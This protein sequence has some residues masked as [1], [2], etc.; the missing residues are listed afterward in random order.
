MNPLCLPLLNF[1]YLSRTS[2]RYR[3][4]G[5]AFT[6]VRV[7]R[8]RTIRERFAFIVFLSREKRP[9]KRSVLPAARCLVDIMGRP[10]FDGVNYST[11][12]KN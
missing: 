3:L 10:R 6:D 2:A 8:V 5:R 9:T 4:A 1:R 7:S 11:A 12:G